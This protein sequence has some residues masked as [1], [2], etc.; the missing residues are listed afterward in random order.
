MILIA[1]YDGLIRSALRRRLEDAGHVVVGEAADGG[2]ALDLLR[3]TAPDV[4]LL[5]M[6]MPGLDGTYVLR[7][8]ANSPHGRTP[9]V[10]ASAG[11]AEEAALATE[12]GADAVLRK[13]SPAGDLL[14][15]VTAV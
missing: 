11:S 1:E 7:S 4:L 12:L 3:R 6:T 13:D 8:L 5:D 9:A 15:A 2:E 14:A 10:V